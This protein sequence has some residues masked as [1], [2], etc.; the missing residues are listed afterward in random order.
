M[1]L[2]RTRAKRSA[3]GPAD[4]GQWA[5]RF[6]KSLLRT[7]RIEGAE[8]NKGSSISTP[9]TCNCERLYNECLPQAL[10]ADAHIGKIG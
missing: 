9:C 2:L 7:D 10:D 3:H 1:T 6:Q 5:G 4:T 8:W